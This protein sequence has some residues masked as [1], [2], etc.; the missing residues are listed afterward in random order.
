MKQFAKVAVAAFAFGLGGVATTLVLTQ[1][2][3]VAQSSS[4]MPS[5]AQ[6][7]LMLDERDIIRVVDDIAVAVD[8]KDWARAR[9]HFTDQI[10]VDFTSLAG[11]QP[12]EIAA[13]DL[14]AG[15]KRSLFADKRSLHMHGNHR[16]TVNGNSAEIYLH[17]YAYNHL[18]SRTG[19]DLWEVWGNYQHKLTRTAQGWKVNSF[20][21]NMTYSSGNERARDFVPGN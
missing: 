7:Q 4:T 13:D 15:W 12:A 14:I 2:T 10:R 21:F 6:L 19:A 16:V 20:S 8:Q 17:G 11:G 1:H 3:A 5:T 9:A 18:S